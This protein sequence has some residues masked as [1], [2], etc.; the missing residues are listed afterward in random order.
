M[1]LVA[2]SMQ[3]IAGH[4]DCRV[5]EIMYKTFFIQNIFFYLTNIVPVANGYFNADHVELASF[6]TINKTPEGTFGIP[7]RLH[8]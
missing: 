4:V 8:R 6:A 7:L 2:I 3:G 1:A 5:R